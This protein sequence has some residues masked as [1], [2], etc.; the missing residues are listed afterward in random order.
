MLSLFNSKIWKWA[1]FS[2]LLNLV[3]NTSLLKFQ[4]S[5]SSGWENV[6]LMNFG[7]KAVKFKLNFIIFQSSAFKLYFDLKLLLSVNYRDLFTL[8]FSY[9]VFSKLV[10]KY[11]SQIWY[12][13]KISDMKIL[14]FDS[15]YPNLLKCFT[16]VNLLIIPK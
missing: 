2:S 15:K 12:L 1:K 10:L 6:D 7:S 11:K 8:Y 16:W 4:S 14:L 3:Y 13:L 9:S 5:S